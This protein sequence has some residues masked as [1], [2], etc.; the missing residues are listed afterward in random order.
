MIEK[1][2]NQKDILVVNP[3]STSTKIALFAFDNLELKYE[4]NIVHND[5]VINSF[6]TIAS[7]EEY[8]R[9]V[10]SK[11]LTR[12]EYDLKN[13]AAVVG[14]GGMLF[15]LKG[16]GYRID[17]VM[18][19]KM[20]SPELPQHASSL[21]A[22]LAYSIAEPLKIPSFIYDS[23]MGCELMDIAKVSGIAGIKKYGATHLLNSRAQAIKY[24]EELER[25]YKELNFINCHMGGGITVNAM[26]EGKVIDVASYDDG[27]MGPERSGGVPLLPFSKKFVNKGY[28]FEEVEKFIAGKGGLYSYLG[29][30]DCREVERMIKSG[31]EHAK[32]IYEAMAYQIAKAIAGLS[33][34]FEGKVD[35]IIITGGIAYSDMLVDMI[36]KFC[37]HIA[38]IIVMPGEKEMEALANGAFRILNGEE[39]IN[40]Y[41]DNI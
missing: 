20:A 10:I 35:V 36:K 29:T 22:L 27:P 25:N 2:N 11:L 40:T 21:G 7:Q 30:K 14:R 3:G 18:Y 23:T 34:A 9:N 1:V 6:P 15:G 33:C 24:A 26:R 32:T 41:N 19:K 4:R 8:R 31:D 37:G 16:G 13:L 39:P 17:E 38:P 12:E 28:S 5:D